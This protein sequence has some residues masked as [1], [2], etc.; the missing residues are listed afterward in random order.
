M[1]KII[2][3]WIWRYSSRANADRTEI[4]KVGIALNWS[5]ITVQ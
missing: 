1:K 4:N 2:D 5:V 3:I